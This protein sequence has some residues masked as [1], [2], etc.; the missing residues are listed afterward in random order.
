MRGQ[1]LGPLLLAPLHVGAAQ[2]GDGRLHAGQRRAQVVGDRRQQ[3][4][5]HA[6]AGLEV[7]GGL[8]PP[9]QGTLV[10]GG[11]QVGGERAEHPLLVRSRGGTSQGE[12]AARR[13]PA[14][15]LAGAR[16]SVPRRPTRRRR[17]PGPP[18]RSRAAELGPER[19]GDLPQEALHRVRP[20][21]QGA[22]QHREHLRLAGEPLGAT[23]PGRRL[24]D[25]PPTAPPS[26]QEDA[27]H[28]HVGRRGDRQVCSG[29][30]KNQLSSSVPSTADV[31]RRPPPAGQRHRDGQGEEAHRLQRRPLDRPRGHHQ[32]GEQ[33]WS[34]HCEQPSGDVAG[35][36]E[37]AAG[38][39][40]RQAAAFVMGHHQHVEVARAADQPLGDS[41]G[42]EAAA[43]V[44]G[45]SRR[46]R[47]GW[48]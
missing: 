47:P 31:A 2:A 11:L 48:R 17:S 1:Q 12:H 22:V 9:S 42:Q 35:A 4:G 23:A 19:L 33:R 6:V 7:L 43:T 39:G 14:R 27:E 41:V 30:V 28:E 18:R 40:R 8:G 25:H 13:T 34:G 15:Y 26:D 29:S 45:C 20:G 24:T 16:R 37:V 21:E 5:A 32:Q 36:A 3:G 10:G 46:P 38:P 44:N